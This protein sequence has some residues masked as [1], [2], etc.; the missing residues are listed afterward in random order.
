MCLYLTDTHTLS[1]PAPAPSLSPVHMR[2]LRRHVQ[3]LKKKKKKTICV[4]HPPAPYVCAYV[5]AHMCAYM[6]PHMHKLAQCLWGIGDGV[7]RDELCIR[8]TK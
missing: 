2:T 4:M 1:L 7:S 8:K 5:C 3:R 6:C